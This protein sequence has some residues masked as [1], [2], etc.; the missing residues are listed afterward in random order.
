VC[1][2]LPPHSPI[3]LPILK[4]QQRHS[5]QTTTSV[6]AL[7]RAAVPRLLLTFDNAES[8]SFL[9]R[10]CETTVC[11]GCIVTDCAKPSS[12][13]LLCFQSASRKGGPL[14]H[15]CSALFS[16]MQGVSKGLYLRPT[17]EFRAMLRCAS[18]SRFEVFR[19]KQSKKKCSR[20]VYE[21]IAIFRDVENYNMG[22]LTTW[23]RRIDKL[24][25]RNADTFDCCFRPYSTA[26]VNSLW[27]NVMFVNS[28]HICIRP[29]QLHL[30]L[31]S[32]PATPSVDKCHPATPSV[33][34]CHPATPSV[35]K[36]H[37][38]TPSVDK[39]SSYTFT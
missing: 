10:C 18:S 12:S 34:K 14:R 19:D 17:T 38:A 33:D 15:K 20:A 25:F 27:Q 2:L 36:C 9:N 29:I 3:D 23:E 11:T 31:I 4:L 1:S 21:G 8:L 5:P 24:K 6:L 32:H 35:D 22:D 28:C 37:P 30:Q 16:R 39:S 26:T 7:E 13:S